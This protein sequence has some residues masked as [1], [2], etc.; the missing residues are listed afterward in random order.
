MTDPS[1]GESSHSSVLSRNIRSRHSTRCFLSDPI[2]DSVLDGIL[3]AGLLAPSSKNRQPWRIMVLHEKSVKEL[4]DVM[5]IAILREI[6][7]LDDDEL[8]ND[9]E[10]ALKTME[11]IKDAPALLVIGYKDSRPYRNAKMLSLG[12]TDRSLVDTLSIGACIENILL[13][14]AERGICSL[15]VGD[16]LYAYDEVMAFLKPDYD[17][18]S[19]VALGYPANEGWNRTPRCV[20][21]IDYR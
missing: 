1:F 19:M 7:K 9:H 3:D 13:E 6:E 5:S 17:V 18:V 12:M 20:D 11:A 21:R 10:M 2:P 16:Y 4:A 14:S 15:W 8:I